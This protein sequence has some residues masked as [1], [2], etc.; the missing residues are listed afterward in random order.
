MTVVTCDI[1]LLPTASRYQ[2]AI[3]LQLM[4]HHRGGHANARRCI[5]VAAPSY[6]PIK[7]RRQVSENEVREAKGEHS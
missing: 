4:N 5:G 2:P 1:R 7:E 6:L 3:P